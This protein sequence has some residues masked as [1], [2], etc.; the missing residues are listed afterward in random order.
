MFFIH[1]RLSPIYVAY[2][3]YGRICVCK[4]V[5][6]YTHTCMHICICK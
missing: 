5:Y 2:I 3:T 1:L 6:T 4:Y